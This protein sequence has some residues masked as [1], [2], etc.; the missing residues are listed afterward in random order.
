MNDPM[1]NGLSFYQYITWLIE[2]HN[3]VAAEYQATYPNVELKLPHP[4]GRGS[5]RM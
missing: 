2:T 3:D 1:F 5:F 4:K